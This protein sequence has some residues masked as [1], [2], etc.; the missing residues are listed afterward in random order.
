MSPRLMLLPAKKAEE[1]KIVSVPDDFDIRDAHRHATALIASVEE[2]DPDYDWD[3]IAIVLEE[4]GFEVQE[5][6]FGP[7]LD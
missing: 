3:D 5:F 4:H 7:D 6:M 1:M 2:D